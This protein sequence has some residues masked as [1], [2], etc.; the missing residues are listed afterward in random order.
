MRWG[1][2][3]ILALAFVGSTKASLVQPCELYGDQSVGPR[4]RIDNLFQCLFSLNIKIRQ[5]NIHGI[6]P[7]RT[8]FV[9]LLAT[10][11]NGPNGYGVFYKYVQAVQEA[12]RLDIP[13]GETFFLQFLP[14][15]ND[16]LKYQRL[17]GFTCTSYGGDRTGFKCS[18]S[19]AT[20]LKLGVIAQILITL[21]LYMF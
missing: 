12:F 21:S 10:L 8:F 11:S 9:Q 20:T 5:G 17:D 14:V 3:V 2:A 13:I 7:A 16:Y 18:Y 6:D 15:Y 19:S 1:V 4:D